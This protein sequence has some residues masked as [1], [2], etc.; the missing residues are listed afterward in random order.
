MTRKG[1]RRT[2]P[3]LSV[4]TAS[5]L[6]AFGALPAYA[7]DP[8]AL[9]T[10]GQVA[11]GSATIGQSGTRMDV[12]QATQKAIINWSSFNIGSAASVNFAQPNSSSVALNRVTSSSGGSQILGRL[13]AN[14]QVFLVNPSGVLFGKTAQVDVGALVATSLN[15]SDSNF[16]AGRYTFASSGTAGPVINEGTLRAADGGYIALLA[17]EVRNQGVI[18]ARL[19]TVALGAGNKVTLDFAGDR[20]VSLAIDEAA[21]T[22][23]VENR[24]VVQADGGTVIL[25]A[26]AAGDLASTVVNNTGLIQA[27]SVSQRDG[28]IRLEGGER[29]VVAVSGTLDASGRAAGEHGGTIKVLGDRVGLSSGAKLD[30]S[31]DAGGGT[32]LVGGNYLGGGPEQNASATYVAEGAQIKADALNSGDG[33]KV[34]LWSN[35]YTGFNGTISARGGAASGNGGFVE[36]SSKNVLQ[37]TGTV[38]ASAPAGQGGAWLLDPN[39]ITIRT[40]GSDTNVSGNPNFTT[41]DDNA[42]V[43]TGSI[44]TALNAGTSVTIT[45]GTAG[46]NSQV[47]DITVE[48]AVAKTAG[49][50]ATLTLN[51]TNGIT[52]N[53]GA[54]V[55]STVGQLGLTLNAGAGGITSLQN[56]NTN[57]G[58]LTFNSA[59][60]M[61]QAGVISGTGSVVKQ[62]TGTLTLSS[63]NTYTGVTTV[64]AGTLSF[65]SI[66][67]VSGG[68]SAL[69]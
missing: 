8:A 63:A 15:I 43:T 32:V 48:N 6:V 44:Q 3:R 14:G 1:D 36:T 62:G 22:A 10:G 17:P 23:L 28:V 35:E 37:A 4:L 18:A 9:P 41:T 2:L 59:G 58:V 13:S 53:A 12:N 25:A 45:T 65:N 31:G 47:G 42:I 51:A 7:L 27:M 52:F 49:G 33:G 38:D 55:T 57:G 64:S 29:G 20:L 5:V 61:T 46:T 34:I 11:A 66:A 68:A 24:H 54:N 19:G 16:L 21:L 60:A 40:A 67:N 30:A 56:V 50:N 39:N 69:G 26:R